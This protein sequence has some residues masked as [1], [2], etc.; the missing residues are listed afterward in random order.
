MNLILID[1]F[2]D[3]ESDIGHN[4]DWFKRLLREDKTIVSPPNICQCDENNKMRGSLGLLTI[5]NVVK[6]NIEDGMAD[7]INGNRGPKELKDDTLPD[8]SLLWTVE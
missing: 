5:T 1:H 3:V 2:L 7:I 8:E 4:R 6:I